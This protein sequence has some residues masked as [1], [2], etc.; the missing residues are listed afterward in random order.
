MVHLDGVDDID[1]KSKF[2]ASSEVLQRL[3]E[4]GKSPL[5][6][7]FQR[8]K[9]WMKWRDVV[10]DTIG[11]SCEPVG[12]SRGTLYVWVRNSTWMQ[13]MTFM[14]EDIRETINRKM[15]S[16]FV[17]MIRFTLDRREVPQEAG[18]QD[19]IKKV[20]AKFAPKD[21]DDR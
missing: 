17:Q 2:S 16:N 14:R 15:G 1:P 4:D 20:I 7:P 5:S 18:D 6:G 3:F 9:L 13:Q 19:E 12:F 10:G 21:S 11:A 8:W